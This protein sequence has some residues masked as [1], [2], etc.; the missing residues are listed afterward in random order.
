MQDMTDRNIKHYHPHHS[1]KCS[2]QE[3]PNAEKTTV[4]F[5]LGDEIPDG[6]IPFLFGTIYKV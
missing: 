3:E 2:K 6:G 5:L 1:N 4:I